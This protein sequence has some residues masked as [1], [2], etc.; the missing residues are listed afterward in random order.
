VIVIHRP[1][2]AWARFSVPADVLDPR[3]LE[4]RN[5]EIDGF[6]SVIVVPQKWGD[7]LFLHKSIRWYDE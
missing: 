6:F 3:I 2:L 5:V 7:F 4:D 1:G